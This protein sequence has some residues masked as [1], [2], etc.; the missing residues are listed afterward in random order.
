[1]VCFSLGVDGCIGFARFSLGLV[2][3]V[4][5]PHPKKGFARGTCLSVICSGAVRCWCWSR[6]AR[7][8]T[9]SPWIVACADCGDADQLGLVLVVNLYLKYRRWL[10]PGREPTFFSGA[11]AGGRTRDGQRRVLSA[12]NWAG[13]VCAGG[14]DMTSDRVN[15]LASTG[16]PARTVH[17]VAGRCWPENCCGS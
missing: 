12:A 11:R 1:M 9:A 5:N 13:F 16:L 7:R 15:F 6:C 8:S 2:S 14:K 10:P 3:H 4:Q 17:R